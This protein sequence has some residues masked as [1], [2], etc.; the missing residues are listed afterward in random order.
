MSIKIVPLGAGQDVGRSCILASFGGKN[1]ML[2]CGMHMGYN[3][4]R[5][6]PDFS[7]ITK[8]GNV[9][10]MIDCLL[11]SHFHLDHCGAL[12]YFTE[13]IGYDG[14]IYMTAPTKAICP[15][16]LE[17]YRKITV[18]RKGDS[19]FFTAQMVKDSMKKVTIINLHES[20]KVCDDLEIKAYYAGH[21]L[22]ACL[23][24]ITI[25]DN[26]IVYTGDYNMTPDRHLGAAWIDKCKPE[27]LITETTYATVIRESKRAREQ[28]FLKKVH[29]C[30]LE[31]GKVLIPVFALGRAQ[32]LCILVE[33]FW[34]RMGLKVPIYFSTGMTSKANNFYKVF[35]NWT[36]E[37]IKKNFV[38]RNMFDF[39][40]IK[41]WESH[42]A[43][44]P[45]PMVLFASPGMLHAGTSLT[46]FK[47]WA[48]DPKNMVI[49]PGYCVAGTVGHKVLAGDKIIE[50]DR[51]SKINVN[52]RVENL[53]F[54]AHADA[55]GIMQMIAMCEPK[56]V[57]FVHGE[58]EKMKYLARQIEDEIKIPVYYPPNGKT[59]TINTKRNIKVDLSL[60]VIKKSL[61]DYLAYTSTAKSL[62]AINIDK[63]GD[64]PCTSANE[65]LIDEYQNRND[66]SINNHI[67]NSIEDVNNSRLNR[68]YSR[69][70]YLNQEVKS[71][72]MILDDV[73]QEN[74]SF[75][76]ISNDVKRENNLNIK[77]EMNVKQEMKVDMPESHYYIKEENLDSN[78]S[79]TFNNQLSPNII[80]NNLNDS[81]KN[82]LSYNLDNEKKRKREINDKFVDE[83]FKLK[84]R[85]FDSNNFTPEGKNKYGIGSETTTTSSISKPIAN[86]PI[87][88]M[89]PIRH[90][91]FRGVILWDLNNDTNNGIE[92][93]LTQRSRWN[94][95][96]WYLNEN[97]SDIAYEVQG[98]SFQDF[99]RDHIKVVS[100]DTIANN[101]GYHD[102]KIKF[103]IR[104]RNCNLKKILQKLRKINEEN[105]K[106]SSRDILALNLLNDIR[107]EH[108]EEELRSY[109]IRRESENEMENGKEQ[110]NEGERME[111]GTVNIREEGEVKEEEN[112]ND[113]V[114]RI[115]E[116]EKKEKEKR[117]EIINVEDRILIELKYYILDNLIT[118]KRIYRKLH[119][120]KTFVFRDSFSI[121]LTSEHSS[122]IQP[123]NQVNLRVEGESALN[124]LISSTGSTHINENI[125]STYVQAGS[126]SPNSYNNNDNTDNNNNNNNAS[127]TTTTSNNNN[128]NNN[129]NSSNNKR[130][131]KEKDKELS[132]TSHDTKSIINDIEPCIS[133]H[134]I[135]MLTHSK[136]NRNSNSVNNENENKGMEKQNHLEK[137]DGSTKNKG[138]EKAEEDD[139]MYDNLEDIY[140]DFSE[141]ENLPSSS[142]S[143]NDDYSIL[144]IRS[145]EVRISPS[146]RL[147]KISWNSEDE[148]IAEEI[149][150]LF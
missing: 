137:N 79:D 73:K 88:Y 87:K 128:N 5:R 50:V 32:E 123:R 104:K 126:S 54:S 129:G 109:P 6:F 114:N 71:E 17:D 103:C 117:Y 147:I 134:E 148:L 91:P 78:L 136:K 41:P 7:Y 74:N 111:E 35:I 116:K 67:N 49:L 139:E 55:K 59:V 3:D 45:G 46:V 11:I 131:E 110:K 127:T 30:V 1:I 122:T 64:L 102:K 121:P 31:G 63:T 112:G 106:N 22:G 57:I 130:K 86:V 84:V 132:K 150:N 23:F 138:K 21:V 115:S 36:N 20:I 142:N 15:L 80:N 48:P 19:N 40:H 24:K 119:E 38:E 94:E 9:N 144:I 85:K 107:R 146:R 120:N 108:L 43:D 92:N 14:P 105:K 68:I 83:N 39:N 100:E 26:S 62:D 141:N 4:E 95:G 29:E 140:D 96:S 51:Y 77:Q 53:S 16:L 69:N 118:K 2:D 75:D 47:K 8:N 65:P 13:M 33:S 25:G 10:E 81:N 125:A 124:L 60:D 27:I 18:E 72:S 37:K 97:K 66:N 52:L 113:I 99:G 98:E 143:N 133:F 149:I 135:E 28:N 101:L 70:I 42:Y 44:N 89:K 90:L 76:N 145:I 82:E 61:D 34:E 58:K 93:S 56:N 12:P